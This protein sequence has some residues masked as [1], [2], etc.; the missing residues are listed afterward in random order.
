MKYFSA[1]ICILLKIQAWAPSPVG[2]SLIS[3]GVTPKSNDFL[4]STQ[5]YL[6]WKLKGTVSM[7]VCLLIAFISFQQ[8]NVLFMTPCILQTSFPYFLLA[9]SSL[10]LVYSS[11][12]S[13]ASY[14]TIFYFVY[15]KYKISLAISDSLGQAE[16]VAYSRKLE[17]SSQNFCSYWFM[18]LCFSNQMHPMLISS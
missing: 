4:P 18:S 14:C 15:F 13:V 2:F 12:Y 7:L 9:F 3:I 16:I 10:L 11:C 17:V 6:A 1:L 5:Y 8:S